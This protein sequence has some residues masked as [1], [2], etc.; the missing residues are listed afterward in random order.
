MFSMRYYHSLVVG[1]FVEWDRWIVMGQ[2][3]QR[4]SKPRL[5]RDTEKYSALGPNSNE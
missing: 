3:E 4:T 1:R 5:N 2:K